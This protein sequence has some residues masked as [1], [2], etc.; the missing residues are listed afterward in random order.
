MKG[1]LGIIQALRID[2]MTI[3][4][5]ANFMEAYKVFLN[6]SLTYNQAK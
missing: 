5:K 3:R 1:I 4:V 2:I 6:H